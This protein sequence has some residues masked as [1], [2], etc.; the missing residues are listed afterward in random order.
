MAQRRGSGPGG[1]PN[2]CGKVGYFAE[3]P[4]AEARR[5]E[6]L[7]EGLAAEKVHGSGVAH[8]CKACANV[9]HGHTRRKNPEACAEIRTR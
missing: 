4:L 6:V 9:P 2:G 1:E 8:E 7:P 3:S 5:Y